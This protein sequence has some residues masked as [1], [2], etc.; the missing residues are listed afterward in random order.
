MDFKMNKPI[1]MFF[2]ILSIFI[3]VGI[4]LTVLVL[5]VLN[6]N[7]IKQCEDKDKDMTEVKRYNIIIM[8]LISVCLLFTFYNLAKSTMLSKKYGNILDAM[9]SN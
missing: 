4:P 9:S 6:Y 1:L 2:G 3:S 5:S 8:A 7:K